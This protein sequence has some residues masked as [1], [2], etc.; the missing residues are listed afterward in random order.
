MLYLHMRRI[1]K[2]R[3]MDLKNYMQKLESVKNKFDES[4]NLHSDIEKDIQT[5][6]VALQVYRFNP[7]ENDISEIYNIMDIIAESQIAFSK[8]TVKAIRYEL[9]S[10]LLYKTNEKIFKDLHSDYLMSDELREP[11]LKTMADKEA[12]IQT[13]LKEINR[14][15]A[16]AEKHKI[17]SKKL[18]QQIEVINGVLSE[19]DDK[20][21][22]KVSVMQIQK[23]IG[24]LRN[25]ADPKLKGI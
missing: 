11:K 18:L 23:D 22:R 1:E 25:T 21:S 17:R 6:Q 5:M 2:E 20:L 14:Y 3:A 16:Y 13:Q 7:Q 8:N 15:L 19:I 24:A 9:A 4:E 12:Y 10:E